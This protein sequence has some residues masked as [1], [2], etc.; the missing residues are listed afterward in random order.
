MSFSEFLNSRRTAAK[1]LVTALRKEFSYVSVLGVDVKAK[2]IHAD[3]RTTSIRPGG[4]T[5]CGFVIKMSN[6]RVFYEYSL[7][8]IAGDM[9]QLA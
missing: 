9:S 2:S 1:A 5:E 4:N 8:D 6:G 3:R 7:D